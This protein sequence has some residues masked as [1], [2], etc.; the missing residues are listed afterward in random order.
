MDTREIKLQTLRE[1]HINGTPVDYINIYSSAWNDNPT[2]RPTVENIRNS[3]EKI[4]FENIF[5]VS[6][7]NTQSIQP[8]VSS[9]VKIWY[10]TQAI[11]DQSNEN[12]NL[13]DEENGQTLTD[14]AN[15]EITG[16]D[17]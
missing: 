6:I 10:Q 4:Q 11:G 15:Q 8:K 16:I 14:F 2:Q 17:N 5:Y 1:T 13:S 3:L 9:I 12:I 7:E